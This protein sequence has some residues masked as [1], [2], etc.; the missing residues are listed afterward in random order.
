MNDYEERDFVKLASLYAHPVQPPMLQWSEPAEPDQTIRYNHVIAVTPF[1]C[2]L[3]TW[4][5]WEE[6]D[7][8]AVDETPW[9][10]FWQAFSTVAEAKRECELEY[11]KR[12]KE[13]LS[14][15]VL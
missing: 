7:S 8:P 10:G 5:G 3:I 11:A 14:R 13:S 6:Y 4:K 2:F 1:G 15:W 9:G 12:L